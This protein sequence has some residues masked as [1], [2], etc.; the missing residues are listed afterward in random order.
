L[1]AIPGPRYWQPN[2]PVVLMV[3]EAIAPSVR[4]GRDGRLRSD[5]LLECQLLEGVQRT[6]AGAERVGFKSSAERPW[7]PLLLEWDAQFFPH[8]V[9]TDEEGVEHFDPAFIT[10]RYTLASEDV[11]LTHKNPD[12]PSDYVS[13]AEPY[14]GLSVLS[15]HASGTMKQRIVS[16]IVKQRLLLPPEYSE[17][18][19]DLTGAELEAYLDE[20]AQAILDAWEPGED[21]ATL[22]T[23]LDA[24]VKLR[25][26]PTLSQALGGFNDAL[27]MQKRTVQL[28]I[29]D[30]TGFDQYRYFATQVA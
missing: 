15:P 5:G 4:H 30:P 22:R 28:D 21:G 24:Y 9:P 8:P 6:A 16:Y 1:R 3:G 17:P 10:R 14:R 26:V 29:E 12:D 18:L 19:Y 7:N 20:N 27:L 25:G 23:A 11:D 2:D 13:N